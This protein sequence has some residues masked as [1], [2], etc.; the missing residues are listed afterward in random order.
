MKLNV[1]LCSEEQKP[2]L[3]QLQSTPLQ[4]VKLFIISNLPSSIALLHQLLPIISLDEG[5][6]YIRTLR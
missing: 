5:E 3:D 6:I 1:I 2:I 4:A